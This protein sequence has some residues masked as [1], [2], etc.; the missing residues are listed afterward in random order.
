MVK[1][2]H[3]NLFARFGAPRA[4]ISDEGTHFFNKVFANLMATYKVKHRKALVYHPQSNGQA[5]ITNRE[6]KRILEKTVHPG[7]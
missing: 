6:L 3:K 7:V 1:F 5:E 4:I 2:V